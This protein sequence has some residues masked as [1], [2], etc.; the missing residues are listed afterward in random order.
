MMHLETGQLHADPSQF[1]SVLPP[2]HV[3]MASWSQKYMQADQMHENL[4]NEIVD[5][6]LYMKPSPAE[7]TLR[8]VLIRKVVNMCAQHE[9]LFPKCKVVSASHCPADAHGVA[10]WPNERGGVLR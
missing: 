6:M 10:V 8:N 7:M 5:W 9:A 2:C 1:Q 4:H 3:L